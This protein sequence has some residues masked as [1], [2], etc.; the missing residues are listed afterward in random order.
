[1]ECSCIR[2]TE[3][4]G[5]SRLFA[6]FTYHPERVSAFYPWATHYAADPPKP[7]QKPPA[8]SNFPIPAAPR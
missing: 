1:M 3:L 6:D 4:P 5:T 7:S 2:Q 8:R